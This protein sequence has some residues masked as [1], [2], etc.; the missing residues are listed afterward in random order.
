MLLLN[1]L[2]YVYMYACV[3]VS[4]PNAECGV[5]TF[6]NYA[7]VNFPMQTVQQDLFALSGDD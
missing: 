3:C 7:S 1:E 4:K 6:K 2:M 5:R